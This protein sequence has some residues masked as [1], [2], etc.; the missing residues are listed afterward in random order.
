MAADKADP[1]LLALLREAAGVVRSTGEHPADEL[2]V[3]LA[4]GTLPDDDALGVQAH[5][6]GCTTCAGLF[7]ALVISREEL[8]DELAL[9]GAV[10]RAT[11]G[12]D[13]SKGSLVERLAALVSFEMPA[14]LAMQARSATEAVDPTLESALD[15]YRAGRHDAAREGFEQALEAGES[16]PVLRFLLGAC[17]LREDRAR[18]AVEHLEAAA[19]AEPSAAEYRL[20]LG[21]ALLLRG[22]GEAAERELRRAA[23]RPGRLRSEARALADRVKEVLSEHPE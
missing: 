18:D 10:P 2:L 17:L 5:L 15:D 16:S 7:D 23:R 1:R 13:S 6:T 22:E 12:T 21:K 20:L 4:E 14:M 8:A 9:P 3:R 11:G 19:E